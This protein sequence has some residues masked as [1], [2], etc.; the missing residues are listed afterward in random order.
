[1]V[2]SS[3]TEQ[4][5]KRIWFVGPSASITI[6]KMGS[7]PLKAIPL[8]APARDQ[9]GVPQIQVE[10]LDFD[11][12]TLSDLNDLEAVCVVLWG[13][14]SNTNAFVHSGKRRAGEELVTWDMELLKEYQGS[15]RALDSV[16]NKMS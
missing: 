2:E 5:P 12:D 11:K 10:L 7:Q 1:M 4:V 13:I 9:M 3:D 6:S 16:T 15:K 8:I 14:W